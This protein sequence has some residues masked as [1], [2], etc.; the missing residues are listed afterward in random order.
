MKAFEV[1]RAMKHQSRISTLNRPPS[2]ATQSGHANDRSNVQLRFDFEQSATTP[3]L[4][5]AAIHDSPASKFALRFAALLEAD[6]SERFDN[7]AISRLA[8][9]IFGNAAGHARDAY[10]AAEAGFNIYLHRIGLDLDDTLAVVERLFA[11]QA[12]LPAQTRRDQNQIDFQQ[13]STPP[14]EAF[15]VMKTAAIRA[16]MA[17]LEPSAGTGNIAVI[18]RLTGAE[19]MRSTHGDESFSHF[20]ASN[21]QHSM[22]NASTTFSHPRRTIMRS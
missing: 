15:L 13:F 17:V 6:P 2:G 21:Q 19:V 7:A 1:K 4:S 22:P 18:A 10:D 3:A 11:E 14:V 20:R 9:E 16:V 12:R 5:T 8:R